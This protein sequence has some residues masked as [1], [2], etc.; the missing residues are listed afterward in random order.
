M[1]NSPAVV[2]FDVIETIFSLESLRSKLEAAGISGQML[3]IWFAHILR[4]AFALDATG[5]YRPFNT[6][7]S[8]TLGSIFAASKQA[9]P[10]ALDDILQGFATLDAHPDA[11]PAMRVFHDNNI[12]MVTLTNGNAG[13]TQKLLERSRLHEFVERTISVD[14][15]RHWKPRREVY[16]YCADVVGV[17]PNRLALLAAHAW[18]IHGARRAGLTAGYVS[19][20]EKPF[21]SIMEE[22]HVTG[23]TLIEVADRLMEKLFI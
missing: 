11:A 9:D 21:P 19:R 22:P 18:D 3:E 16:L 1:A 10:T 17:E 5:I 20:Q 2:A 14:E 4:D 12:R 15:V 6:V 13:T 7:A 23:S 8:A